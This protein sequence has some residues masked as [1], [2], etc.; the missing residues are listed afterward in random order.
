[1]ERPWPRGTTGK[2]GKE[3]RDDGTPCTGGKSRSWWGLQG[4][5]G[6]GP[7]GGLRR[8]GREDFPTTCKMDVIS[9]TDRSPLGPSSRGSH[10]V[11]HRLWVVHRSWAGVS[12]TSSGPPIRRKV[13]V[14]RDSRC[15]LYLGSQSR[16]RLGECLWV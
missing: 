15:R 6:E 11:T 5:V 12:L 3:S 10:K 8:K 1:M 9:E 2:A 16:C 7:R 13:R 14:T 4:P